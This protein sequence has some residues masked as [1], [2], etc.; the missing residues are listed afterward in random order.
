MY[1]FYSQFSHI[2]FYYTQNK[3]NAFQICEKYSTRVHNF[4]F[5]FQYILVLPYIL[6]M[7][8]VVYEVS[9]KLLFF[10]VHLKTSCFNNIIK[11]KLI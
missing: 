2:L 5:D 9:T 8:Y 4:N 10:K 7:T 6:H 1:T 11:S 3:Q